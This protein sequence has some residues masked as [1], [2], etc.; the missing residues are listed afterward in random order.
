[1]SARIS[2]LGY[3]VFGVGDLDAWQRFALDIVGLQAGRGVARQSLALRMDDYEQRLLL[4]ETG[5]DDLVALGWEFDTEDGLE[6]F[7][8]QAKRGG[9]RVSA[10]SSELADGRRVTRLYTC[11][12]P[13]GFQHEFYV[14]AARAPMADTFRSKV[15]RGGFD[16][17]RLGAG[18][19]VTVAKNYKQSVDFYR[20]VLGLKVSDYIKGPIAG[21]DI[22]LDLTFFHAATGRHHS[23]ATVEFPMPKKIHHFMVQANDMNDVGLAYDRCLNA[24]VPIMMGPGHH[25]NDQMFSFYCVTPSGFGLEFGWGGI[26]I[27][28]DHWEVRTYSQPSD[29]GHRPPQATA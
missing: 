26:V 24:G 9:T 25:P 17:G 14:A 27:D 29:W 5:E 20:S 21:T 1:M 18:H 28:D 7:V 10:G 8:D 4:T 23:L 11:D 12:D 15:L 2:N 19:A 3:A 6:V 13:N 22:F 16:A